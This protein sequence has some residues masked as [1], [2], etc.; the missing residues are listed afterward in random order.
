M[1]K[2]KQQRTKLNEKAR[3]IITVKRRVKVDSLALKEESINMTNLVKKTL[4]T[5]D[6]AKLRSNFGHCT[7]VF[8]CQS[9]TSRDFSAFLNKCYEVADRYL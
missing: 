1:T 4:F 2:R 7:F 3:R 8:E 6:A 5:K 9:K